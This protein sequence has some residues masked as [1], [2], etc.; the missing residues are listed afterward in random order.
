[1]SEL[2]IGVMSG[3]SLDG[4][5][6]VL[7][8]VTSNS[9][10]LIFSAEYPFDA[11]LKEDIL[12]AINGQ[13]TLRVIGQIDA[14][15]GKL[16]AN[17]TTAFMTHNNIKKESVRAIGLHGQT[18]WHEPFGEYPFSMQLGNAN[19]LTAQTGV[20]VVS[21]FRQKDVA[22]GGQGA[23]FAP[24]FHQ[25]MFSK[26]ARKVA[27]INIGGFSNITILGENLIGYDS[28]TGNVLM[29]LWIFKRK[30]KTYDKNG[31]WASSGH[32]DANL[33]NKML[34]DP[35]FQ[36]EPPK[37]TG[38]EYFNEKWLE[39]KLEGFGHLIDEDIQ[40]TLLEFTAETIVSEVKKSSAD[41][42]IICGGG[43]KNIA[44]MQKLRAYLR[45]IEVSPSNK[46]GVNSDFMEAMAFAWLA[47]KRIH[48]ESVNLK[49]VT[50]ARENS[51]LGCIYE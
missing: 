13:T 7:C 10:E 31:E 27:V 25:E 33:L 29:D 41:L 14:R 40:A 3:T 30:N 26:L 15:L 34:S 42:A 38:R 12:N 9:C 21:D 1:M 50:G 17:A 32:V 35:Y 23:P 43:V 5:D 6:I 47:Y 46:Y 37:S 49:S 19:I 22:L 24:A 44:L 36:K 28:G 18:L 39:K 45:D 51:I 16:Y 48:K 4:L 2:Y 8:N 11:K 20:S